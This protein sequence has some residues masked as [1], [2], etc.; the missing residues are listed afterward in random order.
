[1][2][3]SLLFSLHLISHQ[4]QFED[5]FVGTYTP[6]PEGSKG[7]YQMRLD[8][9]TGTLSAPNLAIETDNPSFLALAPGG[10][11]L[12]AVDETEKGAWSM[13]LRSVLGSG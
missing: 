1:M 10:K 3:L 7:I 11:F 5:L 2:I 6:H 13:L 9:R 8:A 12:Y 4:P